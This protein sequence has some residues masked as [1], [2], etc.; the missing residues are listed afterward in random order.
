MQN[1]M[2]KIIVAGVGSVVMAAGPRGADTGCVEVSN[3]NAEVLLKV[4]A[5]FAPEQAGRVGGDGLD[6]KI[7]DLNKDID[8]RSRDATQRAVDELKHRLAAVHDPRVRQDLEILIKAGEDNI[9]S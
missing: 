1:L 5:R 3:Q 8:A 2:Q 9:R 4:M 7:L 6:D